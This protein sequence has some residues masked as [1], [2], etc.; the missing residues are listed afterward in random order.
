[1]V[2]IA[3]S[4]GSRISGGGDNKYNNKDPNLVSYCLLC[5]RSENLGYL[6]LTLNMFVPIE[7][8]SGKIFQT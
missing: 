8:R 4:Q 5:R 3:I 1:M 6:L 2:A 7:N